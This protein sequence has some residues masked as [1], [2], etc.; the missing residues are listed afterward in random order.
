M[1]K[2]QIIILILSH[3]FDVQGGGFHVLQTDQVEEISEII[4]HASAGK[5]AP[6]IRRQTGKRSMS[7]CLHTYPFRYLNMAV[8]VGQIL[9]A[10]MSFCVL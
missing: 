3:L 10:E 9:Y 2:K 1:N 8:Y 4:S 7:C 6:L 5:S